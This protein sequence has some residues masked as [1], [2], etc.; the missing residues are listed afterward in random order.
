MK[1]ELGV[2]NIKMELRVNLKSED[3]IIHNVKNDSGDGK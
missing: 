3:E 2:M 1:L